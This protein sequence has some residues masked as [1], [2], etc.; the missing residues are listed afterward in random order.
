MQNLPWKV[1]VCTVVAAVSIASSSYGQNVVPPSPFVGAR[2]TIPFAGSS[3]QHEAAN[4]K[5]GAGFRQQHV[6]FHAYHGQTP[7]PATGPQEFF[8]V[9]GHFT[10]ANKAILNINGVPV[11]EISRRLSADGDGKGGVSTGAVVAG[12]LGVVV[13]GGLLGAAAQKDAAR[14]AAT[15]FGCAINQLIGNNACPR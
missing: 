1:P 15:A 7:F 8:V 6:A 11:D 2:L 10:S 9:D 5:F 3:Q 13:V 12:V 4:L 14:D